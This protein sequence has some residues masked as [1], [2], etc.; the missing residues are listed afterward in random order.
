M[1]SLVKANGPSELKKIEELRF[2]YKNRLSKKEADVENSD[3]FEGLSS[4]IKRTLRYRTKSIDHLRPIW[5][6]NCIK[7]NEIKP[8]RTHHCEVCNRCVFMMDHHCPW[9]NNCLGIEN[10]RYF[11]LFI[12]YLLIGSAWFALT[13]VSIWH[14]HEYVSI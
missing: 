6:R 14:H 9:V 13:I 12:F 3:R 10:Y 5:S 2:I 4:D 11:L 7:C 1:A 8:G